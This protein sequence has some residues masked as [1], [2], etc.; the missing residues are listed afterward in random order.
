M[1]HFLD[2][3]RIW[4]EAPNSCQLLRAAAGFPGSD[5]IVTIASV[6]Q[7]VLMP[8]EEIPDDPHPATTHSGQIR[9]K[10]RRRYSDNSR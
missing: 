5:S 1:E 7:L 8:L 6:Q 3:A 10:G 2:G 9:P 4:G